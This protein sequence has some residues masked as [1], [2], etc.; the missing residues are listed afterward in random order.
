MYKNDLEKY[1]HIG[2]TFRNPEKCFQTKGFHFASV[3][4]IFTRIFKSPYKFGVDLPM[5]HVLSKEEALS[6]REAYKDVPSIT[7]LGHAS[8]LIKIGDTQ[9]LIDP[10]LFGTPATSF[11]RGLKRLPC[12]LQAKELSETNVL[13]L[14]H[15]HADHVHHPSLKSILKKENIQ[16]IV[17]LGMSKTIKRYKFKKPVELDYFEAYQ[18][19][20]TVKITAVPSVHYSDFSNSTLWSGFIISFTDKDGETKNIYFSGDT[21]YGPFIQRDIAPYGPFDVAIIGVGGFDLPYKSRAPVVHTNPEQ[22]ID[23]AKEIQAQKIIGMHWG[24]IRMA[25]EDPNTL[26][27]RMV[28]KAKE[29]GYEGEIKMLRIGETIAI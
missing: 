23:I 10:I 12:P 18:I 5:N 15:D 14:S 22:A 11:L 9:I 1:W 3:R 27:P 29:I 8:F 21:G 17:P 24:T 16:P 6:L 13:L 25:D 19:N 26:F 20:N 4:W 28:Q 2:N 7:W